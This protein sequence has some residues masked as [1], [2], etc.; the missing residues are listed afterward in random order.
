MTINGTSN[1]PAGAEV[2][3]KFRQK[4]AGHWRTYYQYDYRH[5]D[6]ELFSCVKTT[7]KECRQAKDNWLKERFNK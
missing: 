1:C 6:G 5:V 7:L 2:Y 4:T 3:E